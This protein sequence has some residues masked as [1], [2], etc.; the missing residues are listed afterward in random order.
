MNDSAKL[1]T[2]FLDS[3]VVVHMLRGSKP[4]VYLL[5]EEVL[6]KTRLAMNS[7]VLQEVF[8]LAEVQQKPSVLN[9]LQDK[10]TI[11]PVDFSR[12]AAILER[13]KE[14]RN[15]LAH[16]NDILILGSA[17]ECN[18]LV[19]YDQAFSQ[20]NPIEKLKILTPEQ[21]F[22]ELGIERRDCHAAA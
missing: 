18:Y 11:L 6:R 12:S 13:N 14:L 2:A 16:S 17:A 21:F 5:D 8:F 10:L 20:V 3:S 19:T 7:V 15:R 1:P 4:S 9:D 22:A